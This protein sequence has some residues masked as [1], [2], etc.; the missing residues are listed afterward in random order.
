M[1]QDSENI[2]YIDSRVDLTQFQQDLKKA[3]LIARDTGKKLEKNLLTKLELNVA[4]YQ[5]KIKE[6]KKQRKELKD[7]SLETLK[8]DLNIN[9]YSRKFTEAK[10]QLNNYVNNG[11]IKLSR[12]QRKFNSLKGSII[13]V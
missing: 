12:L 4:D 7:G 10:R 11:E 9:R 2:I 5:R 1:S 13:S 6:A 3:D 8:L